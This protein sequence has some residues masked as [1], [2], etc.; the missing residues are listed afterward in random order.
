M[1]NGMAKINVY[2]KKQTGSCDIFI[3]YEAEVEILHADPTV[4]VEADQSVLDRHDEYQV[5]SLFAAIRH[6]AETAL[7]PRQLGAI[8]RVLRAK[9]HDVDFN[10]KKCAELTAAELVRVIDG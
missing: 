3:D 10:S 4:T 1:E 8:I 2:V 7:C 9:Y 5:E 6:G